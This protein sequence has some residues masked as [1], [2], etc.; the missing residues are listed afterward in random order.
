M[1]TMGI[2]RKLDELGRIVIPVEYRKAMN[3]TEG[4]EFEIIAENDSIIL[5]RCHT[6]D[7]FDGSST[8]LIEYKGKLVSLKS[9]KELAK[10]AESYKK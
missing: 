3:F 8:D 9:I 1:K 5:K 10:L 2:K 6:T 7:I 4:E